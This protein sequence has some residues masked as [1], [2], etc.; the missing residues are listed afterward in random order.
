M[1][2][3]GY[4][5]IGRLSPTM[6]LPL[7]ESKDFYRVYLK[8]SNSES[9]SFIASKSEKDSLLSILPNG[10]P[11]TLTIYG[12]GDVEKFSMWTNPNKLSFVQVQ[13]G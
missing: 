3:K 11:F 5:F 7:S 12:E 10:E 13:K 9:L 1:E 8:W 2:I 6:Y 4:Q